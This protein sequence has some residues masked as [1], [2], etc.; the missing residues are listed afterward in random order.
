[1]KLFLNI[2]SDHI[3]VTMV[4]IKAGAKVKTEKE[5]T[6]T[7]VTQNIECLTLDCTVLL[8]TF[9]TSWYHIVNHK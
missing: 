7:I 1:M 8:C 2:R 4:M 6:V 9:A 5:I 3:E